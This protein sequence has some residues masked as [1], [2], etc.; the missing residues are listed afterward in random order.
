MNSRREQG[1][2]RATVPYERFELRENTARNSTTEEHAA[3]EI[4]CPA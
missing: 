4:P 2:F 3:D 1:F